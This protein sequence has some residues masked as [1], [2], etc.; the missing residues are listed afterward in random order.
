[1]PGIPPMHLLVDE[2]VRT[3]EEGNV[4]QHLVT[5]IKVDKIADTTDCNGE[6]GRLES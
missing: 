4:T 6:I 1:M 2:R 3:Y 5:A